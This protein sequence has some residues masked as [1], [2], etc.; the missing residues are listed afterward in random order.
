MRSG[1]AALRRCCVKP[2]VRELTQLHDVVQT[3][4]CQCRVCSCYAACSA[5]HTVNS[6]QGVGSELLPVQ[7]ATTLS[8]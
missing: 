3:G 8:R 5:F 1:S 6:L 4:T 2:R 7:G